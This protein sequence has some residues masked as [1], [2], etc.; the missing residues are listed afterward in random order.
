MRSQRSIGSANR[1]TRRFSR[2]GTSA[3]E[4][5]K[6]FDDPGEFVELPLVN[7]IRPHIKV[8]DQADERNHIGTGSE[9]NGRPAAAN[10]AGVSKPMGASGECARRIR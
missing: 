2:A 7:Q 5:L 1:E 10:E 9:E 8:S 3:A 4:A 6:S